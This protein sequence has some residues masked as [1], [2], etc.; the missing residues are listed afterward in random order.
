MAQKEL[1]PLAVLPEQLTVCK[2][3][4]FSE[5]DLNEGV[6]FLARTSKECSIVCETRR[7][8]LR[9]LAREDGWRALYV[10]G[11]LDFSLTGILA[12]IAGVLAQAQVSIFAVSTYNTDYVLVREE[13]LP[14]AVAALRAVGYYVEREG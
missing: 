3:A 8:P 5:V 14:Q 4:D 13:A 9:T 7:A 1:P 10:S 11:V 2:A 6:W 12:Q